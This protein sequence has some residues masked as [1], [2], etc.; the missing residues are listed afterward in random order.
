MVSAEDVMTESNR[1]GGSE[2][3]PQTSVQNG[4]EHSQKLNFSVSIQE[5]KTKGSIPRNDSQNSLQ[6]HK[7]TRPPL[8]KNA[9]VSLEDLS[10]D[11]LKSV[12]KISENADSDSSREPSISSRQNSE[13]A[14]TTSTD[15]LLGSTSVVLSVKQ[16]VD[17]LSTSDITE[18]QFSEAE[19][20]EVLS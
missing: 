14:D 9:S 18:E 10:D 7:S 12:L 6:A 13:I 17:A 16:V 3:S 11:K 20:L 1:Q 5:V 2:V 4:K 8:K 19:K 15:E